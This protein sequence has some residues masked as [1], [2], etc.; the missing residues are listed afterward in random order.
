[1]KLVLLSTQDNPR[2]R[3]ELVFFS[4]HGFNLQLGFD[5]LEEGINLPGVFGFD[6]QLVSLDLFGVTN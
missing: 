6:Y 4:C 3:V 1:M 5:I 2:Y